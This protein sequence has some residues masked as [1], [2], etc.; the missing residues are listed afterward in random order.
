MTVG[1]RVKRL[2]LAKGW[3]PVRLAMEADVSRNTVHE[4]E[5]MARVRPRAATVHLL[6]RA[7]GVTAAELL[8][9]DEVPRFDDLASAGRS[10]GEPAEGPEDLHVVPGASPPGGVALGIEPAGDRRE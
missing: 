8:G 6:A 1:Q 4:L 10:L 3:G 5:T 9:L 2:R 7:L